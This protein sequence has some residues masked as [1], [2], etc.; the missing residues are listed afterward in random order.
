LF[1]GFSQHYINHKK[2]PLKNYQKARIQLTKDKLLFQQIS[3]FGLKFCLT[4]LD[5]G[6]TEQDIGNWDQPVDL[7]QICFNYRYMAIFR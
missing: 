3:Q 2:Q 6:S 4:K 7:E 5:E 1:A